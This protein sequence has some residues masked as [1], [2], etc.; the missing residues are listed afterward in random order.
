[1]N[2]PPEVE[3]IIARLV[4]E[5]GFRDPRTA[6]TPTVELVW[7]SLKLQRDIYEHTTRRQRAA[8]GAA[9]IAAELPT[10]ARKAVDAVDQLEVGM[11]ALE[12]QAAINEEVE[13]VRL[14]P[15]TRRP[16]G[17]KALAAGTDLEQEL[18]TLR[19]LRTGGL[20]R[21]L[22]ALEGLL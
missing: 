20:D 22:A 9:A 11:L 3:A 12:L 18:H 4:R 15:R 2:L 7:R 16:L 17:G 1:M 6:G 13:Q 8:A 5:F 19:G 14:N 21:K 10:L